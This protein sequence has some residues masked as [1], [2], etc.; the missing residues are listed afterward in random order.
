ML[1]HEK[2]E[3]VIADYIAGVMDKAGLRVE[4]HEYDAWMPHHLPSS[5]VALVTPVRLP[6][7]DQEF[8]L[9]EDAFSTHADLTP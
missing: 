3:R 6:L 1:A 4:R 9:A 8:I 2:Q 5:R 7:N